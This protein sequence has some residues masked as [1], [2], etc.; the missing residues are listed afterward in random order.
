MGF[1]VVRRVRAGL[2]EVNI[3]LILGHSI[4]STPV[5][6]SDKQ[7]GPADCQR[8][9]RSPP[10]PQDLA[11]NLEAAVRSGYI[12]W[13]FVSGSWLTFG[14]ILDGSR[15]LLESS[16]AFLDGS[17]AVL[18]RSWAGLGR[19]WAALGHSWA[20]LGPSRALLGRLLGCLG[21]S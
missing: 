21:R 1:W 16:W 14:R 5:A 12:L 7:K 13:H 10:A 4:L 20:A 19:S 3:W 2:S 8:L 9:R 18:G 15:A 6:P 17:W 11:G